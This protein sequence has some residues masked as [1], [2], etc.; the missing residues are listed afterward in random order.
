M[1]WQSLLNHLKHITSTNPYRTVRRLTFHSSVK[2]GSMSN[3]SSAAAGLVT[4]IDV[5]S[6]RCSGLSFHQLGVNM[7]GLKGL[8]VRESVIL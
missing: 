7:P 4:H 8:W 5:S 2:L 6:V 1:G 3:L